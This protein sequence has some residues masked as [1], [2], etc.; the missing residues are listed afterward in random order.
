MDS[1]EV[2]TISDSAESLA[3]ANIVKECYFEIIGQADLPESEGIYQLT[4]SSDNTLPVLMTLPETA[5]DIKRIYYNTSDDIDDP[6]FNQ[7]YYVDFDEYL[8]RTTG[9]SSSTSNEVDTMEVEGFLFKHMNERYPSFYTTFN[10][11]TILFDAFKSSV[12]DTLT[13][14]RTLCYGSLVPSFQM[15][16]NHVPDLDPRQFQ[17]LLQSAKA[18]AFVELKQV[19]NPKAEA[20]E[21]SNKILA[22]R[23]KQAIGKKPNY[24]GYGRRGRG[25][26]S[27]T[28]CN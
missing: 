26:Y 13:A 5:I 14:S 6:Q 18:Q 16:D 22:Q 12:E 3:V 19:Q 21:R 25:G 4:P 9:L 20:K 11:R 23:T 10:D 7:L 24:R 27:G 1:D 15:V 17:L 28:R 8:R 2:N